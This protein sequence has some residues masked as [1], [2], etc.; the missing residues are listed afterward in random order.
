MGHEIETLGNAPTCPQ[1]LLL[2]ASHEFNGV[3]LWPFTFAIACIFFLSIPQ[4]ARANP[5]AV[6]PQVVNEKRAEIRVLNWDRPFFTGTDIVKRNRNPVACAEERTARV[7][8]SDGLPIDRFRISILKRQ[9]EGTA[10][11][12]QRIQDGCLLLRVRLQVGHGGSEGRTCSQPAASLSVQVL[13]D[14][15]AE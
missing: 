11:G 8:R 14:G 10:L 7:C 1:A 15:P 5:S 12:Q 9:G 13:L 2:L 6:E 4:N 3:S